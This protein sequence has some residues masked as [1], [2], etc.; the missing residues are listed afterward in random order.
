[1]AILKSAVLETHLLKVSYLVKLR[2]IA[3]ALKMKFSRAIFKRVW[4]QLQRFFRNSFYFGS[5]SVVSY[6]ILLN[7]MNYVC[8]CP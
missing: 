7:C 4:L 3:N 1:M 5:P 8:T 2:Q 6:F